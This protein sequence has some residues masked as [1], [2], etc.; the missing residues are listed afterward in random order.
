VPPV[1]A[2]R[3]L[4]LSPEA[5]FF[6]YVSLL[7]AASLALCERLLRSAAASNAQRAGIL[8]A[9]WVCFYVLPLNVFGEREHLMLILALPYMLLAGLRLSGGDCTAAFAGFIG[10]VAALGFGLK[11]YFLIAPALIELYGLAVHR[12]LRSLLRSETIALAIG[13]AA[14]GAAIFVLHPDYVSFIVPAVRLLYDSYDRDLGLQAAQLGALLPNFVLPIIVY[15][16]ARRHGVGGRLSDVL[17]I[18]AAGFLAA[19]L[20]QAKGWFYHLL[21]ALSALW[22]AVAVCVVTGFVQPR[23]SATPSMRRLIGAAGVGALLILLSVPI[24]LGPYNNGYYDELLPAAREYGTGR[25]IYAFSAQGTVGF[26]LVNE[27]HAQWASRFMA[28]WLLP[29][30]L[31]RLAEDPTGNASNRMQLQDIERYAVNAV[32]EDL[33]RTP[34]DLIIVDRSKDVYPVYVQ[35][36]FLAYFSR[37]P[38]FALIW[39]NYAK[40]AATKHFDLWLRRSDTATMTQ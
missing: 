1:L 21:P 15:V 18:A 28:Q 22:L 14:Y 33:Q 23:L 35:I 32:I 30:V 39:R 2:A 37:D 26:P 13:I 19:F 9:I 16:V 20:I 36:D 10:A 34:P 38:R 7:G 29:G 24:R 25:T 31:R 11:P 12:S 27:L 8:A 6:V 5:C 17:A 40:V 4:Q 3:L